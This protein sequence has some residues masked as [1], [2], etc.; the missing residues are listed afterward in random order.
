MGTTTI[1]GINQC[2]LIAERLR[3]AADGKQLRRAVRA[4]LTEVGQPAVD[5]VKRAVMAVE[6]KGVSGGGSVR[7]QQIWEQRRKRPPKG[8]GGHGLR[9]TVARCVKFKVSIRAA[10]IVL[11]FIVD[12]SGMPFT[13]RKL[14]KYLDAQGRWRHPVY[15]H[16]DRW[17]GQTGQEYFANTLRGHQD[18]VKAGVETAIND[19][20]REIS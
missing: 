8:G 18:N 2:R 4:R 3:T 7:R 20:V 6:S 13:Q 5:D 11:G 1:T 12:A 10:A 16:R 9:E 17:V 19:F 15:G 14:P